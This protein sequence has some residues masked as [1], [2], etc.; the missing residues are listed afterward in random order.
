[1]VGVEA[2]SVR[3]TR[4]DQQ[5]GLNPVDDREGA[6]EQQ[7]GLHVRVS[8]G[9]PRHVARPRKIGEGGRVEVARLLHH[10]TK[11]R[12]VVHERAYGKNACPVV[13]ENSGGIL[14]SVLAIR[15]SALNSARSSQ[16]PSAESS[17]GAACT[18]SF[19]PRR[20]ATGVVPD[21]WTGGCPPNLCRRPPTQSRPCRRPRSRR[22]NPP[23]RPSR[24]RG[25]GPRRILSMLATTPS[26]S[27]RRKSPSRSIPS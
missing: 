13:Q 22:R 9:S 26:D 11:R 17:S 2:A 24:R 6:S 12:L 15:E 1:M 5:M 3:K 10:G 7:R 4:I 23:V 18:T 20:S 14:G 8:G 21:D 27:S 16:K 19:P 25:V